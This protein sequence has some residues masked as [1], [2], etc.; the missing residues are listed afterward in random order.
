[1]TGL[2]NDILEKLALEGRISFMPQEEE[3]DIYL[4]T[5]GRMTRYN[6]L[7]LKSTYFSHIVASNLILNA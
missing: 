1:M 6:R 2:K 5:H 3:Y 7:L 4:K